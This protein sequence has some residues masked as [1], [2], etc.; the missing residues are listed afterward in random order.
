MSDNEDFA[1]LFGEFEKKQ[2]SSNK[3]TPKVGDKVTGTVVSI[4]KETLFIDLG[5]KTEGEVGRDEFTDSNGNLS[6][7]VGDT[8]ET[9]VSGSN[10]DTGM[11]L[12]GSQQAKRMHGSDG[13]RQA[14]EEQ[15]P[16][17]GHVT[18]TTKG[19][20][21][22]E[23]AGI[24]GFCP[25]SQIDINFIEDLERF[26]GERLAFRITKFE[27]GRK[28]NLVVSRRALLEEAQQAQALE[29]REHLEVGAVMTGKI[30]TIKE[31]GAF[32]DLGGIEGMIHISELAFG[33]VTHPKDLLSVGQQVEVSVL[34]IEKTDNARQPERIAL[35]IRALEK[36]PWRNVLTDYPV[37]TQVQGK[38]SRLQPFGAF[39]ELTP[40]IDGLAHI[41][42]LAA[43]RRITHPQEVLNV[44]DVVQATILSVDPEKRRISLTLDSKRQ[45]GETVNSEVNLANYGKPKQSLGTFG[46]LLKESMKK[47]E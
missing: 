20:L 45:T 14:Y 42:E 41:S 7:A 11:L 26:I 31:F 12:L 10:A 33:R 47:Q 39:I 35:S 44:G 9:F 13:L 28:I 23:F 1:S 3:R 38:V 27:G 8:I 46:D 22:V 24:R 25:A 16:I 5:A 19:G 2:G 32:V 6:V 4:Q 30:T 37:G 29:T 21:E 43:G 18:G 34:K 15:Q 36:D 40:G 17:E